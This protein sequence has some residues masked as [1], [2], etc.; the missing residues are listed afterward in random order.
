MQGSTKQEACQLFDEVWRRLHAAV[1]R[2]KDPNAFAELF[3]DLRQQ[4][5]REAVQALQNPAAAEKFPGSVLRPGPAAPPPP[6]LAEPE[7]V[8][9]ARMRLD[10]HLWEDSQENL[11]LILH[12]I[13]DS[14]PQAA[15][16]ET[17][18]A[19]RDAI[20][21]SFVESLG[22][23]G[24]AILAI[25]DSG[26]RPPPSRRWKSSFCSTSVVQD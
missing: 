16:D 10:P 8:C 26:D 22:H 2:R 25:C 21:N 20:A 19:M 15:L 4:W 23:P 7:P 17:H 13:Q 9:V 18:S 5:I 1:Q 12:F 24:R 14:P 3:V 6:L 11:E